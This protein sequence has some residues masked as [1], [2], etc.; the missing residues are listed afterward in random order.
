MLRDTSRYLLSF[1]ALVLLHSETCHSYQAHSHD[2]QA[3]CDNI[4]SLCLH[5]S[6][7]DLALC[8]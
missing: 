6:F 7:D 4:T 8:N 5:G 1:K 3:H 2:D